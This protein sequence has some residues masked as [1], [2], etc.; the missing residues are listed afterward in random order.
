[1]SSESID[2]LTFLVNLFSFWNI[3]IQWISHDDLTEKFVSLVSK[4]KLV[5][6]QKSKTALCDLTEKLL[7]SNFET[8]KTLQKSSN[9]SGDQIHARILLKKTLYYIRIYSIFCRLSPF[10]CEWLVLIQMLMI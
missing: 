3:I 2:S 7:P 6:W 8:T 4:A 9:Q 10:H 1:M 5:K